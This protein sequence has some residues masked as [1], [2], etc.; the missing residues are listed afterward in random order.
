MESERGTSREWS[1]DMSNNTSDFDDL[2]LVN[3]DLKIRIQEL[4]Y[5][6]EELEEEISMS[7]DRIYCLEQELE[8][9][10]SA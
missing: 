6:V 4:E 8:E 10:L 3:R 9:I 1:V 2:E 5:T 7:Q